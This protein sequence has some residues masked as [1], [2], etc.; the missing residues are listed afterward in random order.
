MPGTAAS[1][2]SSILAWQR[3]APTASQVSKLDRRN[4]VPK[5]GLI[6]ISAWRSE[7]FVSVGPLPRPYLSSHTEVPHLHSPQLIRMQK[8]LA[9][10]ILYES[11]R[12]HFPLTAPG[13]SYNAR[14]FS[15]LQPQ[16]RLSESLQRA[17]DTSPHTHT[18]LFFPLSHTKPDPPGA[19]QHSAA[20]RP[21]AAKRPQRKPHL[22][23]KVTECFE[24]LTRPVSDM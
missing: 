10:W 14:Q 3:G 12:N 7:A 17:L 6:A 13:R 23:L 20:L 8:R 21:S 1:S 15:Q 9:T 5:S 24:S 4:Q 22:H 19:K 18:Q 11:P 2:P 16:Q